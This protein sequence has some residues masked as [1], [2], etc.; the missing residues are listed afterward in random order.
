MEL[1]ILGFRIFLFYTR[2]WVWVLL[3]IYFILNFE[4]LASNVW[5]QNFGFLNYIFF[6]NSGFQ[7][8][9]SLPPIIMKILRI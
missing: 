3:F 1:L 8:S 9:V 7:A 5:Y 6:F 4:Y 2:F